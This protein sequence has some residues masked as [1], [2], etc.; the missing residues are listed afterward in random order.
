MK[1]VLIFFL[2]LVLFSACDNQEQ[3]LGGGHNPLSDIVLTGAAA[4]GEE[5]VI[6]WSGFGNNAKVSLVDLAGNEYE[7]EI[8]V[9][10]KIKHPSAIA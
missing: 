5:I 4:P 3:A 2:A 7:A 8:R 6:Q 1:R 10:M 9:I